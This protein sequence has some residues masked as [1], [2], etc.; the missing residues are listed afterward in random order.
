M[1]WSTAIG[2]P[3]A[4]M[5]GMDI[6]RNVSD[7]REASSTPLDEALENIEDQLN[8]DSFSIA[9]LP[10]EETGYRTL[11][12]QAD[13]NYDIGL[14][15]NNVVQIDIDAS[16]TD[17]DTVFE[18]TVRQMHGHRYADSLGIDETGLSED[19]FYEKVLNNDEAFGKALVQTT[20]LLGAY[21]EAHV[22]DDLQY[23]EDSSR[24][25]PGFV[26]KMIAGSP[27]T[28][29]SVRG[30]DLHLNNVEIGG[31]SYDFEHHLSTGQMEE[32]VSKYSF[33]ETWQTQLDFYRDEAHVSVS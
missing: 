7:I 14:S 23:Y 32:I 21:A 1:G 15:E 22:A 31:E 28:D 33:S 27:E 30:Y 24:A 19:E 9:V 11:E 16:E 26:E 18:D 29:E 12:E 6:D 25:E 2:T 5:F 13:N 3:L 4:G 10:R 20:D 17:F 8:D